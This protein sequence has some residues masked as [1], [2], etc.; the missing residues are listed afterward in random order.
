[1]A[2]SDSYTLSILGFV[3]FS[4]GAALRLLGA[5]LKE[6]DTYNDS[7]VKELEYTSIG[8]LA[9]S[10]TSFGVISFFSSSINYMNSLSSVPAVPI[11]IV[12]L[13]LIFD[14]KFRIQLDKAILNFLFSHR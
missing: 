8:L 3:L 7:E 1:M 6:N 10:A 14:R 13:M 12:C 4:S 9:L 11:Y 5:I 2:N